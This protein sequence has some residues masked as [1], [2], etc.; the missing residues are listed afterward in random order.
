M[1]KNKVIQE[2]FKLS[3]LLP[4]YWLTW[5]AV[6]ILYAISWL[7][8]KVQLL[9]GR[10]VGRLMMKI[11]GSR[12]KVAKKN[13]E[14]CFP[15]LSEQER[16][17]MLKKNFENTGIG[18]FETGMGWWWPDW[19]VKRK[20]NVSG[21]EHLEQAKSDG[22]GILLLT[23]HYLSLEFSGRATGHVHP[24]VAF[25][26]P[27][28]NALM[29]YF[30]HSGRSRSNKYMIDKTDVKGMIKALRSKETCVYLPDQDYGRKRSI[31]V[32]FFNVEHTAST[33][34]TM[35]FAKVKN[36]KTL[37]L[38]PRRLPDDSGYILEF[39]PALENFPS[40]DDE[41][42][43]IRINKL[44]EQAI[45]REPDQYMWLHRRFKTRPNKAD[46]KFYD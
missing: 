41:Q 27:N 10:I 9:M 14:V 31:F 40:G 43:I 11:G 24:T 44:V 42:D 38:I 2:K 45:L 36:V 3:F 29:E 30:Q 21:L 28:H 37:M 13:I 22:S 33:F 18:L 8:Y 46:P 15:E 26:R 25:Y 19:R 6:I 7:P 23:L 5:L 17:V 1:S 16:Q 32:P 4:K 34:G 12:L 20:I 35:L 39:L